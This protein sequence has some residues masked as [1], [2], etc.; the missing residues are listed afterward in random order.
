MIDARA[1]GEEAREKRVAG[2]GL[3]E[4]GVE[5]VMD[6]G[7]QYWSEAAARDGRVNGYAVVGIGIGIR[8][9][10]LRSR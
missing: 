7:F 5:H 1:R 2:C 8:V 10:I 3:G 4:K 9:G 6:G